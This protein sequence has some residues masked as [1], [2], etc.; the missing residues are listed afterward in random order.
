ETG[1]SLKFETTLVPLIDTIPPTVSITSPTDGATVSG[2]VTIMASLSD[3]VAV[4]GLQFKLDGAN[5][6]S[7][8]TTAP[9]SILWNTASSSLGTHTI[10]AVARDTSGNIGTST[11]ITVTVP[12]TTPPTVSITSPTNGATVSR[13]S[14]ATITASATDNVKVSRVEFYI[15]G[16]L[17][18]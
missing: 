5:F 15:N 13:G 14:T 12:D 4:A 16:A 10:S 6:G 18:C 11:V 7:E 17:K 8:D 3:N 1:R 2:L 9:Y